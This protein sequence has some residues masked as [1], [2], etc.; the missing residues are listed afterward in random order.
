M[1][2]V[3]F[4]SVDDIPAN[5]MRQVTA[6]SSLYDSVQWMRYC[7]LAAGGS[8]YYVALADDN[9]AIV[10]LTA[11]HLY[12]S[13]PPFVLRRPE[14][15]L[16]DQQ[17]ALALYPCLTGVLDGA[18]TLLL[19]AE[20]V[21]GYRQQV[22]SELMTAVCEEAAARQAATICFPYFAS[23]ATAQAASLVLNGPAGAPL[24]TAGVATLTSRWLDF[25]AYVQSLDR[26]RRSSVGRERR[27]FLDA[28][29]RIRV[30]YGISGLGEDTARLQANV[31]NKHGST[32]AVSGILDGYQMLAATVPDHVIT[33]RCERNGELGGV[34]VC[35]RD[36]DDLYVR[37]VGI[38]DDRSSFIYFNTMFYAPVEWSSANGIRRYGFGTAAYQVKRQRGCSFERRYGAIRWPAAH[39][40]ELTESA[41]RR[42]A[43]LCEMLA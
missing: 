1:K 32:S 12:S 38:S 21:K 43:K 14:A 35:L 20:H 4:R 6:H 17:H 19:L 39:R 37:S 27:E 15:L 42:Q 41:A 31:L 33:F 28:G 25:D 26:R 34:A 16:A 5:D 23:Q 8:L 3:K 9:G 18:H 7:E 22:V 40:D 13:P 11:I 10:A 29:Y 30:D 36:A 24:T 2:P